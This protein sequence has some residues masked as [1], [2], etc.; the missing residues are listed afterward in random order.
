M[1]NRRCIIVTAYI[2]G[3]V[4]AIYTPL[5]GDLIICADGG[6]A[7]AVT[8]GLQPDVFIG[9]FDSLEEQQIYCPT[10]IRVPVEKDDTDTMLCLKYGLSLGCREFLILG[11][12][13]GRLDHTIANLQVL[14]YG[15]KEGATVRI[16]DSRNEAFLLSPGVHTIPRR[17]GETLSLFAW[18]GLCSGITLK[19]TKYPLTDGEL[20]PSF[21]LGVSNAVVEEQAEIALKEGILLCIRSKE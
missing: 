19:G 12:M 20:T 16:L 13:G 9:D 4:Q 18:E 11:G 6:Y 17:P 2:P 3:G 7:H 15:L 10:C 21:P 14:S 8:A 1:R 5:L